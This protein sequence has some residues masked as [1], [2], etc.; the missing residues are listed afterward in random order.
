MSKY[1][2]FAL[3][4][5]LFSCE[6]DIDIRFEWKGM[7]P[8]NATNA[9]EF[10]SIFEG[11][12]LPASIFC[13][14][15]DMHMEEVYGKGRYVD[16]E[17]HPTNVNP[18]IDL[19]ITSTSD[20]DSLHPAGTNLT[21]VFTILNGSYFNTL[22]ADGSDGYYINNVY[23]HY[24]FDQPSVALIDL[25]LTKTPILNNTHSFNIKCTLK[26]STVFTGSTQPIKLY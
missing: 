4:F 3:F 12:S 25:L 19:E 15:L 10:P 26:D 8:H 21:D 16:A 7:T 11:D 1:I 6:G 23:S 17:L 2:L 5:V 14:Q 9:T 24:F 18:L 13:I 22:A 20:F